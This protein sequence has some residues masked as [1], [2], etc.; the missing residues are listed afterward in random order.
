MLMN[1]G[2]S[3]NKMLENSPAPVPWICSF[4]LDLCDGGNGTLRSRGVGSGCALLY[5]FVEWE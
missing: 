2:S 4:C 3:P 5:A 1:G